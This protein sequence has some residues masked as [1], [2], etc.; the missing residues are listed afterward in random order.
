VSRVRGLHVY[1]L[2]A[3][4]ALALAWAGHLNAYWMH[5]AII[6]MYYGILA[7]SWSLLAGYV[8]LFSPRH[9]RRSAATRRPCW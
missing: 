6:A 5:V 8:G 7:S 4:A 1:V 3:A 9:S 2:L